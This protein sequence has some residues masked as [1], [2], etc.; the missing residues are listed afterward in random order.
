MNDEPLAPLIGRDEEI[1]L[2]RRAY[3][4]VV[5]GAGARIVTLVGPTHIGKRRLIEE[6]MVEI[7]RG[8]LP[9]R[10]YEGRP[11]A[12]STA[13]GT[14]ARLLRSRFG[15]TE[16]MDSDTARTTL[17]AQ[18]SA[19][20]GDRRVGDV[21]YFLGELMGLA[22]AQSP[23]TRAVA[24]DPSQ[25]RLLR[26][27][28]VRSFVEADAARSPV[29]LR[30]DGL[31][32]TDEDSVELLGYLLENLR[33]KLLVLCTTRPEFLS[34]HTEWALLAGSRHSVV[35]I[36]PVAE[37]DSIKIMQALLARCQGGAAPRLVEA[38]VSMAGGAPGLLEHMVRVFRDSGVLREDPENPGGSWRVDLDRLASARLPLTVEDAVQVRI[39]ALAPHER[40]LL[41]YAAAMG[42]VFWLG[43]LV[44]LG[45][46][47]REPPELWRPESTDD[48]SAVENALADLVTRDYVL[49]LPD[50]AFSDEVEY[51]FKQNLERESISQ[52]TPA[53]A[54]RRYHQT[55]A[56]W[57]AQK[58][59]V[60]NQ[61]EYAAML[62]RH[63]EHAGSITRAAFT[64][65][66][67]GNKAREHFAAK[68]A[69]E[70]YRKGLELLGDDDARRRIDA[71]H[72]HGDVLVLLGR[73][74]EALLAFRE[75][76]GIAY[77]LG[78]RSKGGAA[79]NRLGRLFR[80]T[81]S[82]GPAQRH[83]ETALSLFEKA[84]DQR[85]VASCR[86]DIGRLLWMKGEYESALG[87]M[88]HALEMRKNLGDGRSIALS[89]NNIGLVWRDHGQVPEAREALESALT[90][91][92]E[93]NDP[94][95]IVESLNDLG[96]LALDQGEPQQ[97]LGLF[98][99][100]QD[101][102]TDI[103]ERN[104]IAVVLTNTGAA[105]LRLGDAERAILVLTRAEELCDELG[106]KLHLA[107]AKRGLAKAHL[108]KGELKKARESIKRSVDLFGQVRS[109]PHL[110]MALRTLGEVTG[111]GAWGDGHE[112]KAVDYFLRSIAICQEIG[113]E[114]EVAKSYRAFSS[115]VEGSQH[116][117]HNGDILREAKKL[118]LMA[119]EIFQR[120]QLGTMSRPG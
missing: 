93:L 15:L 105:H 64:Y 89:L 78:L 1:G 88:R 94:L 90:I 17:H 33:G 41:E 25:A 10:V 111:A 50:S 2:L 109:K 66:E 24:E 99:E 83:F 81:G 49:K 14:F 26:R 65:I 19:V 47:D 116:Y 82:L 118:S 112:V 72:N 36:G 35:E 55:I 56:D 18:V 92:R 27:A 100:A 20:L 12:Q 31:H 48:V 76:L 119:D 4:E 96:E 108:A 57:L 120:H 69:D 107:E 97:A 23:M 74:D 3:H 59:S 91:R 44:A 73:T 117:R 70:Y 95:G 43:G 6:L 102:A 39:A 8:P 110:A 34:R 103:G 113:N 13:Y 54:S 62:A 11:G 40:R 46:I 77:R 5:E 84:G 114:L 85:G 32:A 29:C 30:I 67:A 63:L 60:R 80:D 16:T 115:Y 61:E 58:E 53:A 51:V 42:S 45:R 68:R 86:D 106:D 52:L 101:V 21:C 9:T 79:H 75:M 37:D 104:R 71:L 22:F 38:A 28:V 98:Q 87:E 7:R